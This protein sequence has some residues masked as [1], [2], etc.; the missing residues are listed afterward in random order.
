MALRSLILN[1]NKMIIS[2]SEKRFSFNIHNPLRTIQNIVESE[3]TNTKFPLIP[4]S[5]DIYRIER[6]FK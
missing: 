6:R 3:S 5:Q 2:C 4:V 1:E